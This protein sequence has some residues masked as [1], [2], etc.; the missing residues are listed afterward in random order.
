MTFLKQLVCRG[1]KRSN[2]ACVHVSFFLS[3]LAQ[4][5][6]QLELVSFEKNEC[7]SQWISCC[8]KLCDFPVWVE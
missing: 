2:G 6:L 8:G 1:H 4:Q 5:P 7:Y 3:S